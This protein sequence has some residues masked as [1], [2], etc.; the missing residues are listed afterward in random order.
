[1]ENPSW[2]ASPQ[3]SDQW[4]I[5]EI[6]NGVVVSKHSLSRQCTYFGRAED[7]VHIPTSHPSCSRCHARIAFDKSSIPFLQDLNSGNGTIVNK[8]TISKGNNEQ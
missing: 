7:E 8:K 4:F 3:A 1:M 5:E 2:S 6:K